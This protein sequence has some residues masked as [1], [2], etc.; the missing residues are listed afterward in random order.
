MT[1][2]QN[3][4]V[5][6]PNDTVYV[7]G[8]VNG[9]ECV[10]T[11]TGSSSAGTIWTA[12]VAR[13]TPDV[14][15]C[16]ITATSST[17][18]TTTI[19]TTLY[20]GLLD[21]ITDRTK[22]DVYRVIDLAAKGIEGM[23]EDELAEFLAGMKGAYNATDLNRVES[24]VQYV[25]Q[26]LTIAGLHPV[27]ETTLWDRKEFPVREEMERYLGNIRKLRSLLPMAADV[28]AAPEDMDRLTHEEANNIEKILLAVDAAITNISLA[29]L[30]SSE[31][32]AGEV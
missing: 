16:R 11:L 10:F 22:A 17:G 23:T 7:N 14:Y 12:D 32:Y 27:L 25:A 20:Y 15:V 5:T 2:I 1:D 3:I 24:A 30:Y 6:M 31:V 29:W 8:T 26:R 13:A 21:L 28:P 4:A 19:E 9:V 18:S